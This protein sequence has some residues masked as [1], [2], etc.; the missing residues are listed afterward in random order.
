MLTAHEGGD[1]DFGDEFDDF[2]EGADAPA[3]DDFGDFDEGFGEPVEG[4]VGDELREGE[5]PLQPSTPLPLVR[6]LCLFFSCHT[7]LTYVNSHRY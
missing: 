7:L 1:D 5:I 3:D 2:E 6:A 4:A